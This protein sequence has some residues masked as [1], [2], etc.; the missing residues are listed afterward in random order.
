MT[1]GAVLRYSYP[2]SSEPCLKT[3]VNVAYVPPD[4]HALVHETV[5]DVL[6]MER[7]V[8]D[9]REVHL[10]AVPESPV[11]LH[12]E[13]LQHD[14]RRNFIT[15]VME[16]HVFQTA[17]RSDSAG[18]C[19]ESK[20]ETIGLHPRSSSVVFITESCLLAVYENYS[21]ASGEKG[22]LRF[23]PV[24]DVRSVNHLV[25]HRFEVSIHAV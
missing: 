22:S 1:S 4:H 18:G 9:L 8:P 15:D 17:E 10:D 13:S 2:I 16:I 14:N 19:S 21:S 23:F 24:S 12:G 7:V 20:T 3:Y 6:G 5:P 11:V 25:K